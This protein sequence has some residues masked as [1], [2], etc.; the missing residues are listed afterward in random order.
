MDAPDGSFILYSSS[1]HADQDEI[2]RVLHQLC[3]SWGHHNERMLVEEED[4]ITRL[5]YYLDELVKLR[6][7]HV[8]AWVSSNTSKFDGPHSG[9]ALEGL[10]REL[11]SAG[12]ELKRSVQLCKAD[13]ASCHLSCLRTRSHEGPHDCTTNH[14]C[15]HRC[16]FSEEHPG[17]TRSCGLS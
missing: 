13:C 6:L 2:E 10:R 17:A 7:D 5:S 11:E 8:Q 4:W 14:F 9:A 3:R 15:P 1:G 16:V 12:V